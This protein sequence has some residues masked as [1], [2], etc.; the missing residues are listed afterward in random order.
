MF[1]VQVGL[2]VRW[3]VNI[4]TIRLSVGLCTSCIRRIARPAPTS[5]Y[6]IMCVEIYNVQ[7]QHDLTLTAV[8]IRTHIAWA[9]HLPPV[10][11]CF[12]LFYQ[13]AFSDKI[14]RTPVQPLSPLNID[15]DAWIRIREWR[16]H[17]DGLCL[18]ACQM[19]AQ[20]YPSVDLFV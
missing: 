12:I 4:D 2:H 8:I 14:V 18:T 7:T 19:W 13:N 11:D 17:Y 5:F 3:T 20:D 1:A 9:F 15:I 6:Y 16:T 10:I